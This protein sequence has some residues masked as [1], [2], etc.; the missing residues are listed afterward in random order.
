M[1]RDI[2]ETN[3]RVFPY[4]KKRIMKSLINDLQKLIA[5]EIRK[6]EKEKSK[7]EVNE[8]E[9]ELVN[10]KTHLTKILNEI[11][12][13]LHVRNQEEE[14]TN[15]NENEQVNSDLIPNT[16]KNENQTEISLEKKQRLEINESITILKEWKEEAKETE[17]NSDFQ[18]EG[19]IKRRN[20]P[21]Q[22][23]EKEE[24]SLSFI[25]DFDLSDL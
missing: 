5:L 17:L 15:A 22:F 14:N 18:I 24:K 25:L 20:I 11:E 13:Y 7:E 4:I 1:F 9:N 2:Y 10:N 21:M 16:H 6:K 23:N 8:N 19:E 3:M 12:N